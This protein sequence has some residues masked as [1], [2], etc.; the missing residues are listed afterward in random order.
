MSDILVEDPSPGI[1]VITLNRP[2]ALNALSHSMYEELKGLFLACQYDLSV[3]AIILTGAGRAF[4]AGHDTRGGSRSA[5]APEDYGRFQKNTLSMKSIGALIPLMK[6]LPQPVI[7][8]VKGPVA[9]LG[10][11]LA[12]GADI[13]IAGRSTKFVNAFHNAG[14]G[15]EGGIS[16]LL[17]R[18]VGTQKAAE[19]L[20]TGRPVLADEAV[21]VG[22]ALS[23]VEDEAL[24]DTAIEL[25][26][27]IARNSPFGISVTKEALWH[28]LE[29]GSLERAIA[30]ESRGIHLSQATDDAAEKK[31]SFFEKRPPEFKNT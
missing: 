21:R 18:A 30:F 12:L 14:T 6:S 15:C 7:A 22:L 27:D 1:R 31:R 28:N 17:P 20:F 24:L 2:E 19:I 4:T 16:Y 5:V 29:G 11:A 25:A 13:V 10:Y 23:V 9:G 8:A 26:R 3:R